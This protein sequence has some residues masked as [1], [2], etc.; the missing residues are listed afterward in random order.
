MMKELAVLA[1]AALVLCQGAPTDETKSD[2]IP[3][4]DGGEVP[5]AIDVPIESAKQEVV[6]SDD[7]NTDA[8]AWGGW[9][10]R[11]YG[12]WGGRGYGGWGGRGWGGGWGG[13]YGGYRGGWGG[14][15]G[16]G[17]YWG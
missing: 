2:V 9:G 14:G 6:S 8:S 12:G 7:L 17:G 3:Q 11:G 13:G 5:L 16:R 1:I 15:W 4:Q 10:G